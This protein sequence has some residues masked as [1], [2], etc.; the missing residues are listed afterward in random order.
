MNTFLTFPENFLWGSA[1]SGHQIE[2]A[3]KHS[4]WWHWEL[5]TPEQP[6]SGMAVDYWNRFEEDHELLAAMGHQAFRIGIEWARVEPRKGEFDRAAIE[7]YRRMLDSLRRHGIKICLTLH[8][9]VLPHWVAEQG[10]WVN[11]ATVGHFLQY[12]GVILDELGEFPELWITLNEPMVALLAGNLSGDFP[13]Q[14]RS[15]AAFRKAARNMLRA[16]AGAYRLIHQKIAAARVGIAMA[17]PY[18][19]PWESPGL[20]GWYERQ[21]ERF[22]HELLFR[23]WDRS[24]HSGRLHPFF[25]RGKIDGL[26]DSIDFC[27]VNYYF[28]MSLRFAWKKWRTGF[29]DIDSI[30]RGVET[31]DMGWQIWPEGLSKILDEVWGLDGKPIY[32]TENGIADADDQKRPGYLTGH[33]RQIHA[34]LQKGIPVEGYFHWSF[35]DNFEWKEGFEMKFGLVA[36]D[37]A[38]PALKRRPRP[39][40]QLY[41]QIIRDNGFSAG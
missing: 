14:R 26:E 9:W 33:L 10:D 4:D 11:P 1:V 34:A 21:A 41:S 31:T 16:H 8:H 25:G 15:V 35:I 19:A 27:G 6:E 20:R 22:L 37:R 29:L 23:A 32:I 7:Q 36:V 39:S 13:P 24:V 30:P 28:R 18:M 12:V 3:N 5:A 2:G 38:D 40:A 17:Y